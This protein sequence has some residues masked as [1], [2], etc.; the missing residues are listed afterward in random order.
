MAPKVVSK[1]AKDQGSLLSTPGAMKALL[2]VGVFSILMGHDAVHSLLRILRRIPRQ[3]LRAHRRHSG[4]GEPRCG[5][6]HPSGP[7]SEPRRGGLPLRGIPGGDHGR[8]GKGGGKEERL[9]QHATFRDGRRQPAETARPRC[10][11]WRRG[12]SASPAASRGS[13]SASVHGK[14]CVLLPE[15]LCLGGLCDASSWQGH[16]ADGCLAGAALR[17][18]SLQRAVEDVRWEVTRSL[19]QGLRVRIAVQRVSSYV[20]A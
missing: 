19:I 5:Q 9:K 7:R 6:R 20:W 13:R 16:P 3:A 1:K 18:G 11:P 17:L 15:A 10:S 12:A 2:T 8:Y 14:G 4:T